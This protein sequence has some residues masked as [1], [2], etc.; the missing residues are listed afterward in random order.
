MKPVLLALPGNEEWAQSLSRRLDAEVGH[1]EMRRF[2][3][4]E[5][6]V[7]L[8]TGV[9]GRPVILVCTL[10]RPDEKV[11]PL[12][13]LAEAAK[14]FKAS[15]V[16]VVA[17]YLAYLRQDRR[18]R[19]GEAMSSVS[20]AR[21]LSGCVD[22]LVTVDP[23]LHRYRSLGEI[24]SIPTG[25][26]HAAPSIASWIHAELDAP[27]VIGPDRESEQW[28]AEVARCAGAP[29]VVLEK[30]RRGDRAVEVTV[31]EMERWRGHRPVLVD[32]IITTA[33][34]MIETVRLLTRVGLLPPLCIGIHAVFAGQAYS[35]LLESGAARVVTCNTIPHPSN[36]I[37]LRDLLAEGVRNIQE[38][39]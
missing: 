13:F 15:R 22:W 32:D 12:M 6:Y 4:G 38:P 23:H 28:V 25:V 1:V 16:G 9:E 39:I 7:R 31:P 37:D 27:V 30:I 10:D 21:W 11:L 24:Y 2:P 19:S 20:F 17:P 8:D 33:G 14:E 34:T 26:V 5:S 36:A 18:F 3:D 29:Y 35:D